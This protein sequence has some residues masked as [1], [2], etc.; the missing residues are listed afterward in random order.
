[1][2]E[3]EALPCEIKVKI[4]HTLPALQSD[5]EIPFIQNLKKMSGKKT[6]GL[7][8]ATDAAVLVQKKNP[9]PFVIYGPGDPAVIHKPDE[10]IKIEDVI[11]STENLSQ[12]LL[13][14]YLNY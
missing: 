11:E 2:L 4:T 14:T 12:A 13:K 6:I 3:I 10:F 1:L 5:S 9:V 8:Y 7:P